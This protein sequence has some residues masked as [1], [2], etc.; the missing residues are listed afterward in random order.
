[1][2]ELPDRVK[3]DGARRVSCPPSWGALLLKR[4]AGARAETSLS[5]ALGFSREDAEEEGRSKPIIQG[6][7][8]RPLA[9]ERK[10]E[11]RERLKIGP[12]NPSPS[13]PC[14]S[15]KPLTSLFVGGCSRGPKWLREHAED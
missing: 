4:G 2:T 13:A 8:V 11:R 15:P 14:S 10:G 3:W 6:W 7:Q 1:M 5:I 9:S 12:G